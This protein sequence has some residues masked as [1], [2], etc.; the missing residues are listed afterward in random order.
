MIKKYITAAATYLFYFWAAPIATL[1]VSTR[2]LNEVSFTARPQTLL[3]T[4]LLK[5]AGG[6]ERREPTTIY[7]PVRYPIAIA[8]FLHSLAMLKLFLRCSFERLARPARRDDFPI[9]TLITLYKLY[10]NTHYDIPNNQI[11]GSSLGIPPKFINH[12]IGD[13]LFVK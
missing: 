11:F 9:I 10:D 7:L 1:R 8:L 6:E 5:A 4:S 13:P 3:L 12:K 2:R